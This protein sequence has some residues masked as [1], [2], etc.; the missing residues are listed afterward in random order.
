MPVL[1]G[2]GRSLLKAP[3]EIGRMNRDECDRRN[4]DARRSRGC[5]GR[6]GPDRRE[7]SDREAENRRS[8]RA[9]QESPA[10][11]GRVEEPFD[12]AR[13]GAEE[14]QEGRQETFHDLSR[15]F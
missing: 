4:A 6:V 9:G 13:D 5:G 14:G 8:A 1:L 3:Q 7:E 10:D 2:R 15:S 11:L 12:A